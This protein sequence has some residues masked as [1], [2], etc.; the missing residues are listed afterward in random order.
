MR[1]STQATCNV[2]EAVK[3]W[4]KGYQIQYL[5]TS[6]YSNAMSAC[7]MFQ[8]T[9]GMSFCIHLTYEFHLAANLTGV[10]DIWSVI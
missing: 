7:H 5:A 9:Y 6:E 2:L 10:I 1:Q 3:V 8:P 4:C